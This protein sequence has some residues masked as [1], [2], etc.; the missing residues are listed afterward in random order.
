MDRK[1]FDVLM[2]GIGTIAGTVAEM[3]RALPAGSGRLDELAESVCEVSAGLMED[4]MLGD[5]GSAERTGAAE[6]PAAKRERLERIR[7]AVVPAGKTAEKKTA[8]KK[9]GFGLKKPLERVPLA[10]GVGRLLPEC[11]EMLKRQT[12]A[13]GGTC[14]DCGGTFEKTGNNQKRCAACAK[15]K[16]AEAKA[17]WTARQAGGVTLD[18]DWTKNPAATR[19]RLER[20]KAADKR[21]DTIP[22]EGGGA[23]P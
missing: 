10:E 1:T 5:V 21:I 11:G 15:K 16:Q 19:E 2:G 9:T 6:A 17:E 3:R 18:A 14:C 8:E 22:G 4:L 23:E 12:A 13:H 20:I 7:A